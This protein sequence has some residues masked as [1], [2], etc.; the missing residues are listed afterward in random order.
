MAQPATQDQPGETA[1]A[2]AAPQLLDSIGTINIVAYAGR[3]YA[4]PQALGPVDFSQ[5]IGHLPGIQIDDQLANLLSR[6]KN[7]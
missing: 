2:E 4:L 1:D 5:D 6:V 3:Y 7:P